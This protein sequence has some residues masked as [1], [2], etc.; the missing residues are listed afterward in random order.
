MC[1]SDLYQG[2]GGATPEACADDALRAIARH[3]YTA[4]KMSP[5]PPASEGLPW[6]AVIRGAAARM[7]AV[8]DAVGPDVEIGLDPHA[9]IF[10]PVRAH[11]LAEALAPLNP[12]FLEEPLRPENIDALAEFRAHSPVPVATGEMLYTA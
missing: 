5:L 10:E 2:I 8:R 9:R 1:S 4:I 12:F 7:A 3:G 11:Q 6:N